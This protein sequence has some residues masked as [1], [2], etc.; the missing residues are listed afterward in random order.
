[1]KVATSSLHRP[2][3]TYFPFLCLVKQKARLTNET[4]FLLSYG[5]RTLT[6]ANPLQSNNVEAIRIH[7][8]RPSCNEVTNK[9]LLV[10][11]LSIDFG[12]STQD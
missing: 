7:D 9:F 12:V 5:C 2:S 6:L 1:M 4:G 11:I 3:V 8:L 10:V